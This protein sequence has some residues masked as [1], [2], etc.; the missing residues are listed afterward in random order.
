MFFLT[1]V[2][3][4]RAS[5]STVVEITTIKDCSFIHGGMFSIKTYKLAELVQMS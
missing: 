1:A 5:A 3:L 4:L 2:A